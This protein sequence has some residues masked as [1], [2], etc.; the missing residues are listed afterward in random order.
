MPSKKC[1]YSGSL[2]SCS[3]CI[4]R[5]TCD[6]SQQKVVYNK[7]HNI[8][9]K[10]QWMWLRYLELLNVITLYANEQRV[11]K[12]EWLDELQE[13]QVYLGGTEYGKGTN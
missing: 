4:E 7:S 1:I 8:L 13:I 6:L 3:A 11:C 9:T 10:N 2:L 12:T 5:K